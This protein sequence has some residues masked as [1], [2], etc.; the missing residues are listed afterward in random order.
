MFRK[1][2]EKMRQVQLDMDSI[3]QI[4][5]EQNEDIQDYTERTLG[6]KM[7]DEIM[8]QIIEQE[9]VQVIQRRIEEAFE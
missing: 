2:L 4:V 5:V 6:E 1:I 7:S 3:I 8:E 9:V